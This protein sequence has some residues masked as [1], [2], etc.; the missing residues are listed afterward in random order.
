MSWLRKYLGHRKRR[1]C[2]ASGIPPLAA[3]SD[4]PAVADRD[5][6]RRTGPGSPAIEAAIATTLGA[7]RT[8]VREALRRF[9]SEGLL[10]PRGAR[11]NVVGE[12][13]RDEVEC[14]FEIREAL[15]ARRASRRLKERDYAELER[16]LERMK[17]H[18]EDSS[19]LERLDTLFHDRI[20]AHAE[21]HRLKRML[22][23]FEPTS[24]PGGSFRLRRQN[25]GMRPSRNMRR[26]CPQC[27][28]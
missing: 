7:T 21:G 13:K 18:L 25:A 17:T 24:R 10:E 3:R 4:L 27:G 5:F 22:G 14:I 12:L 2:G 28:R 15:A 26:C 9:E 11:G 23:D 1:A 8:P 16:L 6:F 20:L 19:E